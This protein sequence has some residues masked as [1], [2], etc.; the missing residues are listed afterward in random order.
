VGDGGARNSEIVEWYTFLESNRCSKDLKRLR[1]WP[2][3]LE[4]NGFL[5]ESGEVPQVDGLLVRSR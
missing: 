3:S 5:P 2:V 4:P 1:F